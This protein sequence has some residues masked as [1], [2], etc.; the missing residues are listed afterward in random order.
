MLSRVEVGLRPELF[1]GGVDSFLKEAE[2]SMS[3]L[4]EVI[5]WA[6]L[7]DV[8]WLDLPVSREELILALTEIAWDPVFQWMFTG[9]L[10]PSAAGMSGQI[11]DLMQQAPFRPGT[12]WG[13][14]KR[15]RPGVNDAVGRTLLESFE[16]V[17]GRS[18]SQGR[19]AS[20]KLLLLEGPKLNET[21][22]SSLSSEFFCDRS[23]ET[24]SLLPESSL[25]KN[26]RFYQERIRHDLPKLFRKRFSS[27]LFSWADMERF[28]EEGKDRFYT[29][30]REQVQALHTHW[31]EPQEYAYRKNAGFAEPTSFEFQVLMQLGLQRAMRLPQVEPS[32]EMVKSWVLP[33]AQG[34]GI[35]AW[36]EQDVLCVSVEGS[37]GCVSGEKPAWLESMRSVA[38]ATRHLLS[39]TSGVQPIYYTH[40][41]GGAWNE[42]R[43]PFFYRALADAGNRMGLP[44]LSCQW[45]EDESLSGVTLLHT[46]CGGLAPRA[47]FESKS[48]ILPLDR[49]YRVGGQESEHP[50]SIL[51][52]R[53]L[54]FVLESK[55]FY[56]RVVLNALGGWLGGLASLALDSEGAS[57]QLGSLRSSVGQ[58]SLAGLLGSP[59]QEMGFFAV[60]SEKIDAFTDL[61]QRRG[62]QVLDVG[63]FNLTGRF[64]VWEGE[65]PIADLSLAWLRLAPWLNWIWQAS[66]M[67]LD[68]PVQ[69]QA[70]SGEVISASLEEVVLEHFHQDQEV[71]FLQKQSQYSG[72]MDHE[73]QGRSVIKPNMACRSGVIQPKWDSEVGLVLGAGVALA[74]SHVFGMA[75]MAL[76]EAV[77]SVLTL[78]AEYGSPECVLALMES[79]WISSEQ[80]SSDTWKKQELFE[81]Q[82]GLKKAAME[83]S[84]PVVSGSF[85]PGVESVWKKE[86]PLVL[87]VNAVGRVPDIKYCRSSDVKSVGDCIYGL[88]PLDF[89]LLGSE[90]EEDLQKV[91]G[92]PWRLAQPL[93]PLARKL[94]SW[95]GGTLGK[96]QGRLKFARAISGSGM[97]V[98]LMES[99]VGPGLGASIWLPATIHP[100]ELLLG[101]GFHNWIVSV[102][103]EHSRFLE[104]EW[105]ALG[106][107]F[108]KYGVVVVKGS[109]EIFWKDPAPLLTL[110]TEKI[111]WMVRGT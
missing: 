23:L 15:F 102:S 39:A 82:R 64:Q 17:L 98:A 79:F 105:E 55:E 95:M 109:L 30:S 46:S 87:L 1:D 70:S 28:L 89:G 16:M 91:K 47:Q 7:L 2:T 84:L 88:G 37:L 36:D 69:S 45:I 94:Y 29:W 78:G 58:E 92:L 57:V 80:L 106:L 77:R 43:L 85:M 63:V 50:D 81:V 4:S 52:G 22:L 49:I 54:D 24:W 48:K 110:S 99:L 27:P 103:Q 20:G 31:M 90:F 62:L 3:A 42:N 5:R 53:L 59:S 75:Q 107:P 73:V 111:P 101:R 65:A 11:E 25:K 40:T 86:H 72:Q 56:H 10:I 38:G 13:I 93:W 108:Q 12:F 18:L 71:F 14:E 34:F 19:A 32:L 44:V 96:Q 68:A 26:D 9:N 67:S 8:Y 35:F 66:E 21:I 76:D 51:Q 104:E 61:A 6:R 97:L 100:W 60:S 74:K 83:L 33:S 41:L